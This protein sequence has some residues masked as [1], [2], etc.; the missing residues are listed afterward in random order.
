[1]H[2]KKE[3]FGVVKKLFIEGNVTSSSY[4]ISQGYSTANIFIPISANPTKWSNTLKQFLSKNE[5]LTIL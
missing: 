3:T 4:C 5:C 1:M 2:E